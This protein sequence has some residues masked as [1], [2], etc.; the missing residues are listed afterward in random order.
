[1]QQDAH[2]AV[3]SLHPSTRGLEQQINLRDIHSKT[4]PNPP[5]T[6]E[7]SQMIRHE[8]SRPR[9][10]VYL[11]SA[12]T[13]RSAMSLAGTFIPQCHL[14]LLT[15]VP[16][17][18][19][20]T[21]YGQRQAVLS[22]NFSTDSGTRCPH[23]A[24]RPLTEYGWCLFLSLVPRS[25]TPWCPIPAPRIY[26]KILTSTQTLDLHAGSGPAV[27]GTRELNRLKVQTTGTTHT[28]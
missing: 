23:V 25:A 4:F 22:K 27:D 1:M 5:Q 2:L 28:E 9:S 10:R 21:P 16:R 11:A 20:R 17:R 19:S 14:N 26:G 24:S 6:R 15:L 13:V 3:E 12:L 8:L 18:V 7:S